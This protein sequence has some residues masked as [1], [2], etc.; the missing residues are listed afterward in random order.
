MGNFGQWVGWIYWV[1]KSI[2][3]V[4]ICP[5]SKLIIYLPTSRSYSQTTWTKCSVTGQ[6]L[7]AGSQRHLPDICNLHGSR[8][9]FPLTEQ[10]NQ[11]VFKMPKCA[12]K[13][14]WLNLFV[15]SF[16]DVSLCHKSKTLTGPTFWN[17]CAILK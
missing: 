7:R 14:T 9:P 12:I 11:L 10:C 3:L 4:G 5:S 8:V 1:G 16:G 2:Y 17:K 13:I 15:V 6:N